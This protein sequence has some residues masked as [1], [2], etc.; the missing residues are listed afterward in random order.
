MD[1]VRLSRV[2]RSA[3]F[4]KASV[5]SQGGESRL[6]EFGVDEEQSGF[7]FGALGFLLSAVPIDAWVI[8]AVLMVMMVQTW[9]VMFQKFRHTRRVD[10]AN[11]EFREAF[12]GVGTRL[13]Q[14]ADDRSLGERLHYSSLWRLY[15]VA[16]HELR[17]VSYTHRTLPTNRE[18]SCSL[19]AGPYKEKRTTVS[20]SIQNNVTIKTRK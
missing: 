7:G 20:A 14:L 15:Q 18:G 10:E 6:L 12:S 16:V 3:A 9:V 2:A 4:L 8:I 19:R 1:E 11:S 5:Q 13:E 17:A